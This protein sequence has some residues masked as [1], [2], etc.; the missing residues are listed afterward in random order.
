MN[1]PSETTTSINWGR[2][3]LEL[4][5][6][7]LAGK[8][9]EREAYAV[10]PA[11]IRQTSPLLLRVEC[12]RLLAEGETREAAEQLSM[13]V[14]GFAAQSNEREML[15]MMGLL[16]LLYT[17]IGGTPENRTVLD[18]LQEEY[19]RTPGQCSGFVLWA[20]A[21]QGGTS[22]EADHHKR[23]EQADIRYR[24]AAARFADAGEPIWFAGLL[25]DRWVY[26]ADSF[27]DS[28][29][30]ERWLELLR[31]WSTLYPLCGQ[32]YLLLRDDGAE[33][34]E[35]DQLQESAS[36]PEGEEEGLP[37]R[38]HILAQAISHPE[39]PVTGTE[40]FSHDAEVQLFVMPGELDEIVAADNEHNAAAWLRK[41]MR[42]SRSIGSPA[43]FRL[44][45]RLSRTLQERRPDWGALTEEQSA[46]S[47]T[48]A[49]AREE[50]VDQ[51][52]AAQATM[53][54]QLFSGLRFTTG[55]GEEIELK[56]KRRK[57]RELFIYLL[58]QPGYRAMREII[59]EQVFGEGEAA[60]LANHLYVSLHEL[61]H[62]LKASGWEGAVYVR[63]GVI[64]I[65]ESCVGV[66]D[67]E[68]YQALTRV[69]DQLWADDREAAVKLYLDAAKLYGPFGSDLPYAE[70]L[71][72]WRAQLLDRQTLTVKRLV[73]YYGE[74]EDKTRTEHWLNEWI[75][76]RPDHEEAY[77]AMIRFWKGLGHEAE[78][79]SWYRRLER[80]CEEDLATVPLEETRRLLWP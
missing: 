33:S 70:W 80:I 42:L 29:A 27:R 63:G 74:W 61:R 43:A 13:A 71:E 21:R 14:K 18:F 57:A 72:R 50:A 55:A 51:A 37:G 35:Y 39:S 69:G 20:L 49:P 16:A 36:L 22:G 59:L 6:Q 52:A 19:D 34:S 44:A 3:V 62:M 4:E 25:L 2:L 53:Q 8:L 64:G 40:K 47:A 9:P 31:Q 56:W 78:A 24:E 12:I 23:W 11:S 58:L 15:S 48:I 65:E 26:D 28:V 7:Y 60:K 38:F 76:L 68:Q 73:E 10:L 79:I 45:E 30:W 66:I 67:A 17:Q 41:A 5:Q 1:K 46:A 54:V 32:A 77:Q 75:A